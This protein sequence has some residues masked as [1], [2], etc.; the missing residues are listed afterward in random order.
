M[1]FVIHVGIGCG[2]GWSAKTLH[3]KSAAGRHWYLLGLGVEP[4]LQ[5]RGVG[6]ALLQPVLASADREKLVCYLQT[7][8]E[9]NIP[10]YAHYGFKLAGQEK[11][12]LIGPWTWG[13]RR[14]PG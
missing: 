6:G 13:L 7:N 12:T 10:F 14:E 11:A 5:S 9:H 4:S 1:T 8:N 3:K 2:A